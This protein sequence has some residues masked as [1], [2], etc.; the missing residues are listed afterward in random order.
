[1]AEEVVGV[2]FSECGRRANNEDAVAVLVDGSGPCLKTLAVVA[3]GMGGHNAGEVASG[4]TVATCQEAF[5]R[6]NSDS[7]REFSALDASNFLRALLDTVNQRILLRARADPACAGMGTTA[8]IAAVLPNDQAVVAHVGDSRAYLV[9][10]GGIRQLTRDHSVLFERPQ[11]LPLES[12]ISLEALRNDPYA[13]ALTRSLGQEEYVEPDV[14]PPFKLFPGDTLLLVSDGITD[15][16]ESDRILYAHESSPGLGAFCRKLIDTAMARASNDNLTIAALVIGSEHQL[17]KNVRQPPVERAAAWGTTAADARP[18]SQLGPLRGRLGA[19]QTTLLRGA[20]AV[21]L[22]AVGL[23]LGWWLATGGDGR[24]T[25]AEIPVVARPQQ[26]TDQLQT[27]GPPASATDFQTPN[28]SAPSENRRHPDSRGQESPPEKPA[29][30]A[31]SGAPPNPGARISSASAP[32]GMG[33]TVRS[34]ESSSTP[35]PV[36][37]PQGAEP[38]NPQNLIPAGAAETA[39]VGGEERAGTADQWG[40]GEGSARPAEGAEANGTATDSGRGESSRDTSAERRDADGRPLLCEVFG[41]DYDQ[42]EKLWIF[43]IGCSQPISQAQVTVANNRESFSARIAEDRAEKHGGLWPFGYELRVPLTRSDEKLPKGKYI[44]YRIEI[45]GRSL[46][47][48]AF[49]GGRP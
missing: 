20:A 7:S 43:R 32:M 31:G 12:D 17:L 40:K 2:G 16:L 27:A 4:L 39:G 9:R 18:R 49:K 35:P 21:G 14:T 3:D 1:L 10:S 29:P 25:P 5:E 22:L 11:E 24:G 30:P 13:H 15:V 46:V 47:G 38:A 36:L 8:V 6:L 26:L 23:G 33:P 28:A 44:D 37:E 19:P 34:A 48:R 41:Y 42:R 45:P